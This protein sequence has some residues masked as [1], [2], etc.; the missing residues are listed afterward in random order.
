MEFVRKSKEM[1]EQ[2]K[3][4]RSTISK[5]TDRKL[6]FFEVAPQSGGHYQTIQKG[7]SPTKHPAERQA[8][9][10]KDSRATAS[11]KTNSVVVHT[12]CTKNIFCQNIW[13]TQKAHIGV[14][15]VV[16]PDSLPPAGRLISH[17]STWKVTTSDPW[18]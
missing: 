4:I 8:I 9:P 1:V 17:I 3:A 18:V 2:V 11:T 12:M 5:R 15:P 13:I 6:C 10:S 16:Q 14:T 7:Q